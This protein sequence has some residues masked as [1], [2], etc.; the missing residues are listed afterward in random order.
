MTNVVMTRQ[1]PDFNRGYP[2]PFFEDD[3]QA[4]M[5]FAMETHV[6]T[7]SQGSSNR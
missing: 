1:Q 2:E 4:E 7:S 5:G 6:S 3:I